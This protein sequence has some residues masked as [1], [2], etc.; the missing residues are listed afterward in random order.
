MRTIL[1][2]FAGREENIKVALPLYRDILDRNPDTEI[3]LWDLCRDPA[4]SRYLRSINGIDRLQVRTEF[5]A[6]GGVASIGQSR[7]WKYYAGAEFRDAVFVKCDDDVLFL[8]TKAFSAFVQTAAARPGVV[9]SALTINHGASTHLL[10]EVQEMFEQLSVPLLDVHLSAD[11][12]E[13]SHH[14][15]FENWQTIIGRPN[16]VTR[17]SSWVS[18]NCIAYTWEMGRT[19]AETI[20]LRSPARIADRE[21]P[22]RTTSGRTLRHRVGD[23]G[24]VNMQTVVIDAGMVV[25]HL[26]F[27]PQLRSEDLRV[28]SDDELAE[29]RGLYADVGR[30]YLA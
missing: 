15:F 18:I 24:A 26:A 8:E 10:P 20:G 19:I 3:H 23:E 25:G 6:P 30:Q 12:A 13:L 4:D 29:L 11:Y 9:T 21:Y 5:S 7:V 1:Y 27:G 17:A 22:P 14:W 2:V 16:A 28:L